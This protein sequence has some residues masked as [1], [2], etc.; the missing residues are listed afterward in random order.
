MSRTLTYEQ[1]ITWQSILTKLISRFEHLN[2]KFV[3]KENSKLFLT[4]RSLQ[5]VGEIRFCREELI[6]EKKI[7]YVN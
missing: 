5:V 2:K 6:I 7:I 3:N 1:T 4:L